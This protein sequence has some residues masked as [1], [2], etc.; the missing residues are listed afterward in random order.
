M[1]IASAQMTSIVG[2]VHHNI[3]VHLEL[4]AAATKDKVDLIIFPEMSITGYCKE[5]GRA[6]SMPI[7]DPRLVAL[8]NTAI[9]ND[10]MIVAGAPIDIEGALYIGS[11]IFKPNGATDI[12]TKQYLHDGE[13]KFYASSFAYNPV[14]ELKGERISFAICAD[15]DHKQHALNAKRN[16]CT[17][18]L[19]SIFFTK[20]G[21]GTAHR[22]LSTYADELTFSVLMSNYT[23]KVWSFESGGKS[24]F[25]N[26]KGELVI[27]LA[28]N[29]QGLLIVEKREG[30]WVGS[31]L[32]KIE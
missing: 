11:F 10:I 7:N 23:G 17:L 26:E 5:E 12:Y 22:Q 15:I 18:Y 30:K 24:G 13:E 2:E 6:L 8:K 28:E 16:G 25:W 29:R 20:K 1:K 3:Q 21:I 31:S 32:E 19:A 14:L 27:E 9:A 4:I